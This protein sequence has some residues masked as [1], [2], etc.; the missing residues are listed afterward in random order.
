ML[1]LEQL[2]LV[3]TVATATVVFV[4]FA[5]SARKRRDRSLIQAVLDPY[6]KG[7]FEEALQATEHLRD[8]GKDQSYLYYR[9]AILRQLGRLEEAEKCLS[10]CAQLSQQ[11]EGAY[12][13]SIRGGIAEIEKRISISA[14]TQQMLGAVY[15]SRH[16]YAD[17]ITAF[18]AS[19][20]D[21]PDHGSALRDIAEVWLRRGKATE[22]LKW[23][24]LAV[25]AD[26]ATRLLS[27][28]VNEMNLADDL[29][30]LAWA[31]A[32]ALKDGLQ[33]ERLVSEAEQLVV[34]KAVTAFA[35]VHLHAGFAYAALGDPEHSLR[36]LQAAA[37]SDSQGISGRYARAAVAELSGRKGEGANSLTFGETGTDGNLS[38]SHAL[39]KKSIC[40]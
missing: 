40:R 33:V 29:A 35:Q 26:R 15:L 23:A 30:T 6:R 36:H 14:N 13:R 31:A 17:A 25:D 22:A 27:R 10:E 11:N 3:L 34:G 2:L 20:R 4:F 32:A 18:E 9:G 8:T 24:A 19:L 1:F 39:R 16:R 28:D 12:G 7:D 37:Q 21:C 5:S 38:E